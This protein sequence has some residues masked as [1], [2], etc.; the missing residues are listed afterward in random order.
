[1]S[2]FLNGSI[3]SFEPNLTMQ[4]SLFDENIAVESGVTLKEIGPN[5]DNKPRSQSGRNRMMDPKHMSRREYERVHAI[6][7]TN[8]CGCRV[9][10]RM[11]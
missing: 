5:K 3:N 9:I 7:D 8:R 1:M 11:P 10:R 4:Q 2:Q 6:C